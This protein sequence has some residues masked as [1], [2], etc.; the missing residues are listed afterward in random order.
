M[1]DSEVDPRTD[2]HDR[3]NPSPEVGKS[4]PHKAPGG[5]GTDT[6]SDPSKQ[7]GTTGKTTKQ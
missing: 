2:R 3:P 5:L 4:E 1:G 7:D 6:P